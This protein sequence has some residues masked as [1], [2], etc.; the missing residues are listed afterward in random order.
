MPGANYIHC[1]DTN[2]SA[3]AR[4]TLNA[5]NADQLS[6]TRIDSDIQQQPSSWM[7]KMETTEL[8]RSRRKGDCSPPGAR[9]EG[10]MEMEYF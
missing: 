6:N 2:A 8:K 7:S 10:A 3:K 9:I 5:P 4:V 1:L